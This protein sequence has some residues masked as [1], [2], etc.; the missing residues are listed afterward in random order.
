MRKN[1]VETVMR[2]RQ[3]ENDKKEGTVVRKSKKDKVDRTELRQ[4]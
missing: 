2:Q 3:S 1:R 4:K